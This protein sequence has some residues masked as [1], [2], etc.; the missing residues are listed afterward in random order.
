MKFIGKVILPWVVGVALLAHGLTAE[1]SLIESHL[2]RYVLTQSAAGRAIAETLLGQSLGAVHDLKSAQ[3]AMDLLLNRTSPSVLKALELELERLELG[4]RAVFSANSLDH[5][6]F[7]KW[8]ARSEQ[9]PFRLSS[10]TELILDQ[11]ITA[12]FASNFA[13]QSEFERLGLRYPKIAPSRRNPFFSFASRELS[14]SELQGHA[15][16]ILK[17]SPLLPQEMRAAAASK[18][19]KIPGSNADFELFLLQADD[20]EKTQAALE[21]ALTAFKP[22]GFDR[23]FL[24]MIFEELRASPSSDA[25]TLSLLLPFTR[26]STI[27]GAEFPRLANDALMRISA[28]LGK[29]LPARG[30][31]TSGVLRSD[32]MDILLHEPVRSIEAVDPGAPLKALRVKFENGHQ[33]IFKPMGSE[34]GYANLE[35][36]AE[37]ILFTREVN[38]YDMAE[39]WL[40]NARARERGQSHV[41]VPTTAEVV[42][43]HQGVSYGVGS[44]QYVQPGLVAIADFMRSHPTDWAKLTHAPAWQETLDR[45]R[46]IDFLLGYAERLANSRFGRNQFD[47]LMIHYESKDRFTL[48]MIENGIRRGSARG[49][50]IDNLPAKEHIPHDLKSHIMGLDT[51][52][53]RRTYADRLADQGIE[54]F[55]G[56]IKA[57]QH[58]ILYG[59]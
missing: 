8:A 13:L 36:P 48:V 40:G 58:R 28:R 1:A 26:G 53:F 39:H 29:S 6:G 27:P 31:P 12:L 19:L 9:G 14:A 38:A 33:A 15:L 21:Y 5:V 23:N 22:L 2:A 45:I 56:R 11:E 16:D 52:A 17:S 37:H 59:P 42:L 41:E 34:P 50:E 47:H 44:L 30:S 7:L 18:L 55:L 46:T 35:R 25:R 20:A 3:Q 51:K 43:V 57:A 24:R 10:P 49:I 32:P 54:N 4:S